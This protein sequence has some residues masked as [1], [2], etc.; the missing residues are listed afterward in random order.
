MH[1]AR[2]GG[3]RARLDVR[4]RTRDRARRG[5]AAEEGHDEVG[6][7]LAHQFLIGVVAVVRHR[8]GDAGA[9]KTFNRAEHGD[10]E[11][12]PEEHLRRFPFEVGN[13]EGGQ[14][15]RN[16]AELRADRLDGKVEDRDEGCRKDEHDDGARQMRDPALPGRTAHRVALGPELHEE[17]ARERD[18]ERPEVHRVDVGRDRAHLT[19]EVSGHLLDAKPQEVLHL[20]QADHDGDA[21]GEADHDRD[22]NELDEAP[23]LE[24]THEKEDHARA[25]GG[26]HQVAQ[27]VLCDQAVDDDDEGARGAADLHAAAAEKRNQKARDD[28]RVDARFGRNAR[29]DAEGHGKRQR[30]HADR[31]AG[32]DVAAQHVGVVAAKRLQK[33]GREVRQGHVVEKL[34]HVFFEGAHFGVGM[35]RGKSQP[36]IVRKKHRL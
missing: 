12:R 19:E 1:H 24:E 22:R 31:E 32:R 18:A 17:E 8:V 14:G 2:H 25:H 35:G 11:H 4:H 36:I 10:R 26:D 7:A 27:T 16:A 34:P 30:H 21:V 23:E 5:N 33:Y 3:S 13:R 6:D 15:L 29:G 9:Q 20:L 28:G